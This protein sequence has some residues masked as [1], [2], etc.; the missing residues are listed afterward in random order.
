MY[1]LL[2]GQMRTRMKSYKTWKLS[3][4]S[5]FHS[6]VSVPCF[7]A[8][9]YQKSFSSSTISENLQMK[10]LQV[11]YVVLENK[12]NNVDPVSVPEDLN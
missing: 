10:N 4:R 8:K 12:E 2:Q 6:R 7:T 3:A 11:I 9:R 5:I 1:R